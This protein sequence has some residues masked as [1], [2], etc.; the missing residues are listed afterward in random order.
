MKGVILAGGVGSRLDPLTRVTN[1]H[2][3]PV[4]N[5]PM[6]F[7]PIQTLVNAGLRDILIVTGGPHARLDRVSAGRVSTVQPW[8][9]VSYLGL[10]SYQDRGSTPSSPTS[11]CRAAASS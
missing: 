8:L 2:L 1:K 11:P 6:I 7:Y 5:H 10:P 3:L 4:Y 9:V